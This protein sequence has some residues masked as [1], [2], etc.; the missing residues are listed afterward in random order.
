MTKTEYT[1]GIAESDER[2]LLYGCSLVD[3]GDGGIALILDVPGLTHALLDSAEA[4]AV[5]GPRAQAVA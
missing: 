1:E 3:T 2:L 5:T 4:V